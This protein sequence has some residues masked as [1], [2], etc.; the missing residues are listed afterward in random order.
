MTNKFLYFLKPLSS[1]PSRALT[2]QI[3]DEIISSL[4]PKGDKEEEGEMEMLV[5][6][7]HA[8]MKFIG[9]FET[10]LLLYSVVGIWDWRRMNAYGGR[11]ESK[12]IPLLPLLLM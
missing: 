8:K 4:N 3:P 12:S 7:E 11:H 9:P 5:L 6:V 1:L 10:V 2:L